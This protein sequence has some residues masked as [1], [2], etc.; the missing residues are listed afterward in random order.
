MTKSIP[1]TRGHV[2]LV[3]DADFEWLS[4]FK[5]HAMK[6]PHTFYA[7]R[8]ARKNGKKFTV[9]MH[10]EINETP[11]RLKTDHINGDG[12]DNRKANLRSVTHQDN[13]IN[14]AR[15]TAKRPQY[16]GVSWHK[17]QEKWLAQI[18][19][20]CRN[21]YIGIFQTAE[22]A[23]AAYEVKRAEVRNGKITREDV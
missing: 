1:L 14:N 5:W 10:R 7:T 16:R 6:Q 11:D 13:M 20:N 2:A 15:H 17:R 8:S 9:W 22:L 21:I 12:L 19:V 23:S 18:T 3:D 4:Q